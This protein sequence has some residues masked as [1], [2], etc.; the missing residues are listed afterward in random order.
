MNKETQAAIVDRVML[1]PTNWIVF[2][3]CLL[4]RCRLELN[5]AQTIDRACMQMQVL[6]EQYFDEEP[7]VSQRVAFIYSVPY[8]PR[9]SVK[10][11][12]ADSM[13]R[14]G[15]L[16]T[17]GKLIFLEYVLLLRLYVYVCRVHTTTVT[18]NTTY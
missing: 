9:W 13:M 1:H 3:T 16:R 8:P 11:E 7:G 12:L 4:A 10:K 14:V 6:I 18:T 5:K 15:M 2:T 17:A